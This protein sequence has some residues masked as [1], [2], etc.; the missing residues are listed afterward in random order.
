M[1]QKIKGRF[2]VL[3]SFVLALVFTTTTMSFK[4][5]LY[6]VQNPTRTFKVNAEFNKRLEYRFKKFAEGNRNKKVL[7]VIDSRGGQ[8]SILFKMLKLIKKYNITYETLCFFCASAGLMIQVDSKKRYFVQNSTVVYHYYYGNAKDI[9]L[10][11]VYLDVIKAYV[12]KSIR[13]STQLMLKMTPNIN[14]AYI[15]KRV[16]QSRSLSTMSDDWRIGA[17]EIEAIGLGKVISDKEVYKLIKE[18]K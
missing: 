15:K 11:T 3:T 6:S 12:K 7:L 16:R 14:S 8:V 18:Y 4:D 17:I 5:K 10:N 13:L 1:V 9:L 2:S